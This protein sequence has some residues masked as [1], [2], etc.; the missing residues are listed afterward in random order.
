MKIVNADVALSA[1]HVLRQQ[2]TRRESLVQ[3]ISQG[4]NWN[5]EALTNRTAVERE[6]SQATPLRTEPSLLDMAQTSPPASLR[7][8]R[9]QQLGPRSGA[10][11]AAGLTARSLTDIETLAARSL[12][13]LVSSLAGWVEPN[14]PQSVPTELPVGPVARTQIQLLIATMERLSGRKFEIFE[15]EELEERLRTPDSGTY[16]AYPA[17]AQGA[18]PAGAAPE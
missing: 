17:A 16:P 5:P 1:G 14:A 2:H 9:G 15:P 12:Q 10:A 7:P 8:D 3:G 13:P 11:G 6:Q 4:G 18:A